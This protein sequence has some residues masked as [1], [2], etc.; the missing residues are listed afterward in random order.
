MQVMIESSH[1]YGSK[2]FL[3]YVYMLGGADRGC[4]WLWLQM[5]EVMQPGWGDVAGGGEGDPPADLA[6]WEGS[7]ESLSTWSGPPRQVP[8]DW[9]KQLRKPQV[10]QSRQYTD[11]ALLPI[12]SL[13][14]PLP[15]P[16]PL[17]L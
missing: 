3:S 4:M 6:N 9:N 15:L 8:T 14:L 12:I 11:L 17:M 10:F 13:V 5:G 16:L 2:T 1:Y 7:Q